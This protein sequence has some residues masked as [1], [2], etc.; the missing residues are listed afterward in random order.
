VKKW[1]LDN[2]KSEAE[3]APTAQITCQN[4]KIFRGDTGTFITGGSVPRPSGRGGEK[5]EK[6]EECRGKG[7]E[8][9][10]RKGVEIGRKYP[11]SFRCFR[12]LYL[13]FS[14]VQFISVAL[15]TP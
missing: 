5:R 14:L 8:T 10:G 2:Y 11:P 15:Y 4:S 12:Q 3:I 6:E 1:K 13:H 7:R 9:K